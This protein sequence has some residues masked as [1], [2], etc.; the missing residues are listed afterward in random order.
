MLEQPGQPDRHIALFRRTT[1]EAIA[2]EMRRLDADEVYGEVLRH[3]NA[4]P[5]VPKPQLRS[6]RATRAKATK[7]TATKEKAAPRKA[8]PRKRASKG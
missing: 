3:T 5:P 1:S 8:A 7:K 6:I 2:E 4:P